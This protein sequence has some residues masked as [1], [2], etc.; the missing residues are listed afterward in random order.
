MRKIK[1]QLRVR[2]DIYKDLKICSIVKGKKTAEMLEIM[3]ATYIKE[4]PY[5]VI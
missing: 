4:H 2:E 3:I 5:N 1:L